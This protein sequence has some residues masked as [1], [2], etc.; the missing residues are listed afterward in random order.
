M[1]TGTDNVQPTPITK[2]R[3]FPISI[4]NSDNNNSSTISINSNSNSSWGLTTLKNSVTSLFNGSSNSNNNNSTN[5]NANGTRL[6]VYYDLS[7]TAIKITATA[8]NSITIQEVKEP[9]RATVIVRDKAEPLTDYEHVP[10]IFYSSTAGTLAAPPSPYFVIHSASEFPRALEKI[11]NLQRDALQLY[12]PLKIVRRYLRQ[13]KIDTVAAYIKTL[14]PGVYPHT[15]AVDWTQV[16]VRTT[17]MHNT[18]NQFKQVADA[19]SCCKLENATVQLIIATD[20]SENDPEILSATKK[21]RMNIVLA[22]C[23]SWSNVEV[24]RKAV[25]NAQKQ[26]SN[27]IRFDYVN[28]DTF[29]LKQLEQSLG[30]FDTTP[31]EQPILESIKE[32]IIALQYMADEG[33][34]LDSDISK[35]DYAAAV[36]TLSAFNISPIIAI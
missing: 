7:N 2:T 5:S 27:F 34:G 18:T 8:T 24:V 14:Q 3:L 33:A 28:P 21:C 19:L 10:H 9:S 25:A 31:L 30:V 36:K 11:I 26:T 12:E 1:D 6:Y 16:Y 22:C 17:H 20:A 32:G 4:P 29:K 15:A 23:K 35:T 13:H